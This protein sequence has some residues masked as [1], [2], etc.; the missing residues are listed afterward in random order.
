MQCRISDN[1]SDSRYIKN[2]IIQRIRFGVFESRGWFRWLCTFH[3]INKYKIPHYLTQLLPKGTHSYNTCNSDDITTC[4]S[5]TK[6]FK[7]SFFPWSIVE[8]NKLDLKILSSSYLVFR[9]YLIKRI[10]PLEAPVYNIHNPLSLK[11]LTRLRLRPSH[12]NEHRFN[13]NFENCLNPFCTCS[14]EVE[15][16]SHFFLQCHHF[17]AFLHH[18]V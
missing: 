16:T 4:Q 1:W 13:Q 18:F 10:W 7:L 11:L 14:L 8:W 3:K 9:N 17:T 5:R 12:L 6:T 15:P 2:Q